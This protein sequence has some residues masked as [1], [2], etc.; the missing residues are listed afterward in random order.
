MQ[1][2]QP[3]PIIIYHEYLSI[4]RSRSKKY[5]SH[6]DFLTTSFSQRISYNVVL[7][8]SFAQCISHNVFLTTSFSCFFTKSFSQRFSH[9]VAHTNSSTQQSPLNVNIYAYF[10]SVV[11]V[12]QNISNPSKFR[13]P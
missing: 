4:K 2:P 6:N 11:H 1:S 9:N 7:T 10:F 5:L 13:P 12:S 8:P 3:M